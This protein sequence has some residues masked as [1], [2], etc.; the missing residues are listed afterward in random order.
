MSNS[1]LTAKTSNGSMMWMLRA[2]LAILVVMIFATTLGIVTQTQTRH[3]TYIEL[4]KLS[5]EL[6]LLKIEEQRL[7][8]EQHTFSA[9]PQ[10][11][12]RAVSELGMF[13]PSADSRRVI[14][15][16]AKPATESS[17]TSE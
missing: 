3:E 1:H 14:T 11:A 6:N 10:V 13:F 9:T 17:Q 4:Q 7:M 12:S 2:V 8:I 16:S 15:P 5:R